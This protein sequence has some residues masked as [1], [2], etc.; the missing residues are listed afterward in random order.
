VAQEIGKSSIVLE[1]RAW[2]VLLFCGVARPSRFLMWPAHPRLRKRRAVDGR[3]RIHGYGLCPCLV[4]L[5]RRSLVL[6][7]TGMGA[8]MGHTTVHCEEFGGDAADT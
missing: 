6:F 5:I 3:S 2:G 1:P 4:R 8:I 7:D